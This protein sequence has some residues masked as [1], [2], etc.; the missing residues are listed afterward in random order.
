MLRMKKGVV[1]SIVIG[2]LLIVLISVGIVASSVGGEASKMDTML[3]DDMHQH[4]SMA[5]V[6]KQIT[7]MG[8]TIQ[9]ETPNMKATGP[10]HSLIVYTTWL[11]LDLG[12]TPEGAL[13]S[14]HL[15]RAS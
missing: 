6:K 13:T 10:K 7:D 1:W 9:Q 12:F 8:Y 5:E 3:K 4:K 2:V 14:Y 15:D 11:T